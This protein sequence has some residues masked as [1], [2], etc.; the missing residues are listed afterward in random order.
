MIKSTLVVLSGVTVTRHDWKDLR[1]DIG[2]NTLTHSRSQSVPIYSNIFWFEFILTIS[3]VY[4]LLTCF[5]DSAPSNF[6]IQTF[7][8]S[9]LFPMNGITYRDSVLSVFILS[10]L[11]QC[12]IVRIKFLIETRTLR[13]HVI[14]CVNYNFKKFGV[15]KVYP[16]CNQD[17]M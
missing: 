8:V 5:R 9:A 15:N 13:R 1:I 12:W 7:R 6:G 2:M 3:D 17:F 16:V 14:F 11:Q 4:Y 10:R